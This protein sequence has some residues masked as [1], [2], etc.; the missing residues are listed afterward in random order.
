MT[1]SA[2]LVTIAT[3]PFQILLM[4]AVVAHAAQAFLGAL[5]KR[6]QNRLIATLRLRPAA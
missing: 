2:L 3:H 4:V 5:S 6:R 1:S